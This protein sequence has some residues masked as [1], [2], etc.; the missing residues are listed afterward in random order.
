MATEIQKVRPTLAGLEVGETASFPIT[1][2]KGVRTQ[3]SE[4]GLMMQRTYKTWTN[5]EER[6]IVVK[7]MY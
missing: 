4:L 5:R 7:R 6:L 3:A 1:R 2:L